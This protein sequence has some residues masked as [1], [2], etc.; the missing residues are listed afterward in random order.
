MR[1]RRNGAPSK[2]G[3][4]KGGCTSGTV[5]RAMLPP[6]VRQARQC[7]GTENHQEWIS[8]H[9]NH[10][11]GR[12]N[13][14]ATPG[15]R[16]YR[17]TFRNKPKLNQCPGQSPKRESGKRALFRKTEL[18]G[19][20]AVSQIEIQPNGAEAPSGQV[21]FNSQRKTAQYNQIFT[22]NR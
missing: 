22:P 13:C 9:P 5:K 12:N 8:N 17:P 6:P 2:A 4:Q 3:K 18:C 1:D 19:R 20:P 7:G 21:R 11:S 15:D 10:R 14:Q 16:R